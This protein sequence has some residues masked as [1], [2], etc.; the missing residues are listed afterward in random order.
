MTLKTQVFYMSQVFNV[1][2]FRFLLFNFKTIND[3]LSK[4]YTKILYNVRAPLPLGSTICGKYI[5][6]FKSVSLVSKCVNPKYL[7]F[8]NTPVIYLMFSMSCLVRRSIFLM[9]TVWVCWRP[10]SRPLG[11]D[12]ILRF[13]KTPSRTSP[14]NYRMNL[15]SEV[16]RTFSFLKWE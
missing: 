12:C 16:S 7:F 15:N 5:Y 3:I 9:Y 10:S 2:V 11:K 13:Y 6:Q 4:K 14:A 1:L 8:W